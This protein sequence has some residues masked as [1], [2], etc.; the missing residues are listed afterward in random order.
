[1]GNHWA[2]KE[3]MD[4]ARKFLPVKENH[5]LSGLP[6]HFSSSDLKEIRKNLLSCKPL[7][8]YFSLK[9]DDAIFFSC[10]KVFP[11]PSM[12]TSVWVFLGVEI[13]LPP[14]TVLELAQLAM[15]DRQQEGED[16]A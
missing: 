11:M 4:V 1:M 10:V 16:P 13:P 9:T 3:E 2:G 7:M 12:V 15:D 5:V 14:D 8:E 6:L